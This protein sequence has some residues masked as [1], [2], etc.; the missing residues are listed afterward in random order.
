MRKILEEFK[1]WL[2]YIACY[3]GELYIE[4]EYA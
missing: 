3:L 2:S 1:E 4:V